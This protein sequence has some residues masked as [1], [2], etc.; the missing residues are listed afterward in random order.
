[1]RQLFAKDSDADL[2]NAYRVNAGGSYRILEAARL[3]DVGQVIYFSTLGTHTGANVPVL[4]ENSSQRPASMYGATKLT[5]ELLGRAYRHRFGLDLRCVPFPPL[6]GPGADVD[7]FSSPIN[8]IIQEPGLG[9]PYTVPRHRESPMRGIYLK[10][11][12]RAFLELQR[13]SPQAMKSRF[14]VLEGVESTADEMAETVHAILP[15]AEIRFADETL[16]G[17]AGTRTTINESR[18]RL[19]WGWKARYSMDEAIAD[20]LQEVRGDPER[21]G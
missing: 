12:R 18:A 5:G 8:R 9:R 19:E 17:A 11:A 21:Y 7:T 6:F 16:D 14:C 1:V 13:A 4:D 20:F 15:E 3:F 2:W 10:D